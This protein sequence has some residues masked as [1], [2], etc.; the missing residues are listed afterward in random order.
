VLTLGGQPFLHAH[1]ATTY[2]NTSVGARAG[3]FSESGTGANVGVGYVA[4]ASNTTGFQNTASGSWALAA[5]TTGYSNVAIGSTALR[6]NMTG[7]NNIAL[8]T[9]ALQQNTDGS[10]NIAIGTDAATN[11]VGG[12]YNI[13]VGHWGA[14]MDDRTIRIGTSGDQ[15]RT[16]IAGI[17]GVTTGR[18]N[19][20]AVLIDTDGQLGTVSSSRRVKDDI[21]DMDTGSSGLMKLRPVT[22]HYKSDQN[23]AGRTL[24]Y[25][26]IAEEVADVYPGLVAHSTDGQIET[27]MYQFLPP[28]LLNEYQKQQ[29]TIDELR[30]RVEALTQAVAALRDRKQ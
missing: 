12:S 25:G 18:A 27:V 3:S 1:G 15:T 16:F 9:S 28:M 10:S 14:E 13:H 7:K 21:A 26:L 5:N 2:P 30:V 23:P 8:G 19:A 4:L 22:F 6:A 24:Q 11:L 20:V 17:R 29:R